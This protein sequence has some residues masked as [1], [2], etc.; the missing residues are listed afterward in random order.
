MPC[1]HFPTEGVNATRR[2]GSE[3]MSTTVREVRMMEQLIPLDPHFG[4]N[5]GFFIRH[6]P[7]ESQAE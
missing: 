5:L 7:A 6:R 1:G 4:S 3:T 2:R